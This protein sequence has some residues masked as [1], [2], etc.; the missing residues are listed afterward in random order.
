MTKENSKRKI[1]VTALAGFTA[2]QGVAGNLSTVYAKGAQED[3]SSKEETKQAQKEASKKEQLEAQI[4]EAQEKVDAA[5]KE[6]DAKNAEAE[7]AKQEVGTANQAYTSQNT[8]VQTGY[9]T[10]N[11][12]IATIIK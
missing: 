11:S 8:V 4:K 7:A 6:A 5:Q 3:T 2:A 12:V 10:L 1:L 9:D